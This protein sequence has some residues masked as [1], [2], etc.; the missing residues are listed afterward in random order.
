MRTLY[1]VIIAFSVFLAITGVVCGVLFGVVLRENSHKYKCVFNTKLNKHVCVVDD[2]NGQCNSPNCCKFSTNGNVC[3]WDCKGKYEGGNCNFSTNHYYR[4]NSSGGCVVAPSGVTTPYFNDPC[5]GETCHKHSDGGSSNDDTKGGSGDTS[6]NKVLNNGSLIKISDSPGSTN[7]GQLIACYQ[8]SEGTNTITVA[9][10]SIDGSRAFSIEQYG[11]VFNDDKN[12]ANWSLLRTDPFSSSYTISKMPFQIEYG[13]EGKYTGVAFVGQIAQGFSFVTSDMKVFENGT[14]KLSS[15]IPTVY[16]QERFALSPNH[17]TMY[18]QYLTTFR[19]NNSGAISTN[20]KSFDAK[21]TDSAITTYGTD[22]KDL[23]IFTSIKE[24]EIVMLWNKGNGQVGTDAV[25]SQSV[26]TFLSGSLPYQQITNLGS[27][28]CIS[29]GCEYIVLSGSNGFVVLKRKNSTYTANLEHPEKWKYTII[30]KPNHPNVTN[31]CI[32]SD[33]KV[34]AFTSTE[35]THS[36]I[37]VTNLQDEKLVHTQ[38]LADDEP[39]VEL[40]QGGLFVHKVNNSTGKYIVLTS[41][42][43]TARTAIFYGVVQYQ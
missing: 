14:L 13:N 20:L 27:H 39:N 9:T 12:T 22:N 3:K 29:K 10:V 21:T 25:E 24:N 23:S 36:V 42:K 41:Y 8:S 30:A 11:L 32:S 28:V 19:L 18:Y 2:L 38:T 40:S 31:I 43:S 26:N 5:C 4:K 7:T 15:L 35:Q 16:G 33:G 37:H 6:H 17:S 1:I 34:I